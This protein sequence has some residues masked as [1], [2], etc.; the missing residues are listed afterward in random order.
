MN[1]TEKLTESKMHQAIASHFFDGL[2]SQP[3]KSKSQKKSEEHHQEVEEVLDDQFEL[4][5][6]QLLDKVQRKACRKLPKTSSGLHVFIS[7]AINSCIVLTAAPFKIF[8]KPLFALY[9]LIT[10]MVTLRYFNNYKSYSVFE[11][12]ELYSFVKKK[13]QV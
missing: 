5:D 12:E 9:F 1:S 8:P 10:I 13:S 2:S 6:E 3:Q 7:L 11:F 4:E